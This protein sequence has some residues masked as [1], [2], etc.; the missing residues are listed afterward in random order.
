LA[1]ARASLPPTAPRRFDVVGQAFAAF[2]LTGLIAAVIE[3]RD[4]GPADPLVLA[5]VAAFV[6]AGAAF[7]AHERRV[8]EPMLP[9]EVFK[10]PAFSAAIAFGVIVNLAYYGTIFVLSLYLQQAH[11]WPPLGAGLAF[12]PLTATFIVSN[13]ASGWAV[14]RFGS[15]APMVVGAVVGA[16]GYA[17]L[18]GL[19]G[20]S[21]FAA[22]LPGFLLI[23]SGMG[24]GVPA[25]TTAI[26][27]SVGREWSGI[28]SAVLNAARQAGGAIGVAMFGLITSAA[29]P[30]GGL[31]GSA[32]ASGVLLLAG[33]VIAGLRVRPARS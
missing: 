29:G 26:L 27:A 23:P 33:A 32:I 25:M 24:L 1:H 14:A 16:A 18:L 31:H 21:P 7:V 22:M 8:A 6:A 9:L 17:L 15:R 10:A 12:L 28:A 4:R 2:G 19:D 13:L 11:H 30:V 20:T 5:G 3:M